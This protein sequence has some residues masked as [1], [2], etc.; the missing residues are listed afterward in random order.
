MTVSAREAY[1]SGRASRCGNGTPAARPARNSS[2]T[3]ASIR[4]DD[5][6]SERVVSGGRFADGRARMAGAS[7]FFAGSSRRRCDPLP[8]PPSR[9]ALARERGLHGARAVAHDCAPERRVRRRPLLSSFARPLPRNEARSGG[10]EERRAAPG[11][12]SILATPQF[13]RRSAGGSVLPAPAVPRHVLLRDRR[14]RA[15]AQ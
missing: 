1:S 5:Q 13:A 3:V 15:A 9:H 6:S 11:G 7:Q 12:S 14:H 4:S 10:V 2:E 8:H